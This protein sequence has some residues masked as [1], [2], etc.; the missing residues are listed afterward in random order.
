MYAYLYKQQKVTRKK[1]GEH[2]EMSGSL[3][4]QGPVDSVMY[5]Q[6]YVRQSAGG[7]SRHEN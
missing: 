7:Y 4:L 2:V 6:L 1:A 3:A 5:R